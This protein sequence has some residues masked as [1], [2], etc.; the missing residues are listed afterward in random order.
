M[1][2]EF[3]SHRASSEGVAQ[4]VEQRK[5][6]LALSSSGGIG[7]RNGL[8]IHRVTPCRFKSGLEDHYKNILYEVIKM[9]IEA[10]KLLIE[11]RINLL[12]ARG[13]HNDR[14]V[15]KLKRRLRNL[16]K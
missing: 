4:L 9:T 6:S 7:R 3:E 5:F 1:C 12:Q 15:N 16:D 10:K 8:K 2:R 14:I 11:G 13:S